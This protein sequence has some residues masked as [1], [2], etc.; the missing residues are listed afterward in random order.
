M[1]AI[2]V[3]IIIVCTIACN[4]EGD[5]TKVD[6]NDVVVGPIVHDSLTQEQL[7][8]VKKIHAIFSDV[9][10]VSFEETI[11][12]FRRDQNPDKEILIWERMA[13][14]YQKYMSAHPSSSYDQKHEAF[15]LL[16]MRSMMS[17]E[18]AITES[19]IKVLSQD[20]VKELLQNYNSQ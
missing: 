10:T 16:L 1:R 2:L 17:D 14:A 3:L 18:E 11:D 20:E 6:P 12:N 7:T 8:R 9:Y 15:I 4:S 5:T 19:K 13:G